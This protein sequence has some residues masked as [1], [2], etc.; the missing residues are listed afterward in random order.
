M[1]EYVVKIGGLDHT[2]LLDEAEAKRLDATPVETNA[3]A[4]ANK[5]APKST[6]RRE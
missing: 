2:F 4:P 1:K 5:A 6:K 3:K